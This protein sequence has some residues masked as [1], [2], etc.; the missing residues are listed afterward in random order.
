MLYLVMEYCEQYEQ[1]LALVKRTDLPAGGLLCWVDRKNPAAMFQSH[2]DAR[3]AI[4]RTEYYRLAFEDEG[5][6][7]P[8]KKFCKI[9]SVRIVNRGGE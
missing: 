4:S 5:E 3:A 7:W 8:Q 2:A 9:I 6:E 1:P